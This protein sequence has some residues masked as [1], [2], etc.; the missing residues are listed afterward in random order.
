VPTDPAPTTRYS[1]RRAKKALRLTEVVYGRPFAIATFVDDEAAVRFAEAYAVP[2]DTAG[3]ASAQLTDEPLP[4][5]GPDDP[6]PA[7]GSI[8][9]TPRGTTGLIG[10]ADALDNLGG[11]NPKSDPDLM[12]ERQPFVATA[13]DIGDYPSRLADLGPDDLADA[14]MADPTVQMDPAVMEVLQTSAAH[15]VALAK[16]ME[17]RRRLA[18]TAAIAGASVVP[19]PPRSAAEAVER[20]HQAADAANSDSAATD[21]FLAETGRTEVVPRMEL[22][23]G[24]MV[25]RRTAQGGTYVI[26]Q[27]PPTDG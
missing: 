7:E 14:I 10:V 5:G 20:A 9:D 12:D 15:A 8:G 22:V 17:D 27:E 1:I 3:P 19:E 16:A 11:Q 24:R 26:D 4:F 6:P 2:I 18:T 13:P 25:P 23:D 21:A